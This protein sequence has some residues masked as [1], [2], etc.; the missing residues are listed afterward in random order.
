MVLGTRPNDLEKEALLSSI[1]HTTSGAK[2][3]RDELG[4]RHLVVSQATSSRK[5]EEVASTQRPAWLVD[6]L[7]PDQVFG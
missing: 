1:V 4:I 5:M 2:E 6:I 3:R 7:R